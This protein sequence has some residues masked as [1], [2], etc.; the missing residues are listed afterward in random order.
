MIALNS[1]TCYVQLHWKQWP[2]NK[3]YKFHFY[4]L[5][6]FWFEWK[7]ILQRLDNFF[8]RDHYMWEKQ[9]WISFIYPLTLCNLYRNVQWR[10]I[11]MTIWYCTK[12]S[13]GNTYSCQLAA[14]KVKYKPE[15]EAWHSSLPYCVLYI[16]KL[17]YW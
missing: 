2:N 1:E 3:P 15:G 16:W 17:C 12:K 13:F 10:C 7:S 11:M 5:T 6:I 4:C 9:V 14:S 8:L